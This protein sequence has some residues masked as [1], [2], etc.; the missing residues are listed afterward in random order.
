MEECW[1]EDGYFNR[2]YSLSDDE[3]DGCQEAALAAIN[4]ALDNLI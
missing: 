2:K 3:F 1:S 4:Y